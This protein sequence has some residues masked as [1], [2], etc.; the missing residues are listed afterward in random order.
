MLSWQ[1]RAGPLKTRTI[2]GRFQTR[3]LFRGFANIL[4][5]W[6]LTPQP[7]L[8][9]PEMCR[10]PCRPHAETLRDRNHAWKV[11]AVRSFQTRGLIRGGKPTPRLESLNPQRCSAP[12][13]VELL[14][15]ALERLTA[16][17][18]PGGGA[19]P[20]PFSERRDL[21]ARL[22]SQGNECAGIR[23]CSDF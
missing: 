18:R 3:G 4:L 16:P 14:A 15:E 19:E 2:P 10:Q 8:I 21:H 17:A 9:P 7:Q 6:N 22:S 20:F 5:V 1:C 12:L 11:V 23:H 13:R